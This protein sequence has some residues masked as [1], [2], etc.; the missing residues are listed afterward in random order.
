MSTR[1]PNVANSAFV[2][3]RSTTRSSGA[4]SPT[5]S[6]SILP[7]VRGDDRAQVGD[8]RRGHGLAEPDGPPERRGLEDLGVRDGDPDADAGA[9]ADLGRAPGEVGQ[10]GEQL[11]HEAGHGDR[12]LAVA[13]VEALL[14]LADDR[15]LVV[16]RPRVVRPDLRPEAVLERRD[17]PAAAR[18]VLGV[19]A[20]DDEQVER[21]ADL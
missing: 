19:R 16:E 12:R 4:S 8:A 13:A 3:S 9:L 1:R 14:L 15:E 18:V 21:Q 17:D 11:L 5:D 6:S 2:I 7:T 10:L 20:G